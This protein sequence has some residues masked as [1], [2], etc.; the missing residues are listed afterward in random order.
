MEARWGRSRQWATQEINWLGAVELLVAATGK[1]TYQF[2]VGAIRPA[3]RL[4]DD[5][6][7]EFLW[8]YQEAAKTGEPVTEA[9]IRSALDASR[10]Y[11]RTREMWERYQEDTNVPQ[12]RRIALT[13][14]EAEALGDPYENRAYSGDLVGKAK[15]KGGGVLYDIVAFSRPRHFLARLGYPYTRIVQRRF[16]R[17]SAAAMLRAV[18]RA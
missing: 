5:D 1:D 8:V 17:D 18:V 13:R 4:L 9:A 12:A 7:E 14:E 6:P 3:A 2:S 16:A 15:A 10:G 11:T